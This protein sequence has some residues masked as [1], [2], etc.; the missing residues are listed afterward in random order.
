MVERAVIL[1]KL[2]AGDVFHAESPNG[3]SLVCL[4]TRVDEGT[5]YARTVTTQYSLRFDRTTGEAEWGGGGAPCI[6]DS[7][8]PLPVE[9]YHVILG[10]D[11]K[12]R[13]EQDVDKLKLNDAEK[14]ALVFVDS[15][16]SQNQ[17]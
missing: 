6:I 12:Y 17:L 16:Y 3:A 7:V 5:I 1:Q 13:L 2:D 10:I 11:R 8:A 9:I 4:V 14:R 15:H